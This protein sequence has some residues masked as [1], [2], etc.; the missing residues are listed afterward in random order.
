MCIQMQDNIVMQDNINETLYIYIYINI[1]IN[2]N[3][4][5]KI[6]EIILFVEI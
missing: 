3:M 1:L 6:K 4:Y 2:N 5:V